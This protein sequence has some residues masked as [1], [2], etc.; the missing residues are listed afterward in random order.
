MFCFGDGLDPMVAASCP[1]FNFGAIGHGCASSQ[2]GDGA[3]LSASGTSIPDTIVLSASGELPNALS[4]FLQGDVNT[5]SGILFGDGVRCAAGSL[6]R[7]FIH[8]A[9]DGNVS[10]PSGGDPSISVQSAHLGD[11]IPHG[12]V[13]YYQTY[14]RDPS[15]SFCTGLGFNV[16]NG[17]QVQW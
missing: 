12:S 4:L 3:Q 11:P 10:A 6:N 8:N 2:V 1:C 7:L 16:T 17:I 5:N 9:S 13:R 15:L 14:Y